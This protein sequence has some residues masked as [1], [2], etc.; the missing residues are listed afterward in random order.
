M[1]RLE[2]EDKKLMFDTIEEEE[3]GEMQEEGRYDL[4]DWLG[5]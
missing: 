5:E 1:K 2:R 3:N 4:S